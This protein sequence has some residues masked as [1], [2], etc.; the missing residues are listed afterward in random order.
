MKAI[1]SIYTFT[2]RKQYKKQTYLDMQKIEAYTLIL[3]CAYAKRHIGEITLYCDINFYEFIKKY[4]LCDLWDNIDYTAL[5]NIPK[6]IDYSIFWTYPKMY[7]HSIQ[8]EPFVALDADLYFWRNLRYHDNPSLDFIYAHPEIDNIGNQYPSFHKEERYKDIFKNLEII[9]DGP[10]MNTAILYCR[11]NSFYK[12][13]MEITTEF[14]RRVSKTGK[15]E[16]YNDWVHTIFCE[17]RIIKSLL[18]KY[19]LKTAPQYDIP[20]YV[21]SCVEQENDRDFKLSD[22]DIF[23]LWGLKNKIGSRHKIRLEDQLCY[24][25]IKEFPYYQ[26]Y[27]EI[28]KKNLK[29]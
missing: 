5:E 2:N 13:L 23:H 22:G 8:D 9:E 27:I 11:D 29:K 10:N 16:K 17:Q 15:S 6:D 3:S 4:D 14:A 18:K 12:E 19:N 20:F 25:I 28:F 26:H 24:E 7:I 1:H 21:H